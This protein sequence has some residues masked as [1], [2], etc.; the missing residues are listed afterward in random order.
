MNMDE[1]IDFESDDDGVMATK[2]DDD[3]EEEP[4]AIYDQPNNLP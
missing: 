1:D 4:W 2:D 3:E